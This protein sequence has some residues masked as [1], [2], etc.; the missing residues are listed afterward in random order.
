MEPVEIKTQ[1]E[2]S[3]GHLQDDFQLTED[4]MDTQKEGRKTVVPYLLEMSPEFRRLNEVRQQAWEAPGGDEYFANI[5][6]GRNNTDQ[7]N[8]TRYYKFMKVVGCELDR[9]TKAFQLQPPASHP[10]AILDFC[11]A[12]GAFLEIGLKKNPG[13]HAL[14]FTLPISCGGYRNCLEE[15]PRV[16]RVFLDVTMLAA[17]MDVD[18][19]PA[20]HPDAENFLPRQLKEDQFFDL[21]ICDGQT[22]DQHSRASY[23]E[24]RE[25]RRLSLTQLA[26]GLQH[27]RSGGTMIVSFRKLEA[28]STVNFIWTFQ[29]FSSVRLFKPKKAS[30]KRSSFYMIASGIESQHTE[31]I[32]AVARWKRAWQLATFAS[33]EEYDKMVW[34]EDPSGESLIESFGADLVD[35]GKMV[36]KI[37][38]DAL[39]EAPFMKGS[40]ESMEKE[41]GT[42]M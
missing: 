20:G 15:T 16:K 5:S 33:D 27:L 3:A 14:A 37:Q 21:I 25:G 19:I 35:L 22:L 31:A 6:R 18:Q 10:V 38:A 26:L 39:A 9:I 32:E 8:S 24:K 34:E 4:S 23:R 30:S 13:S 11:M 12:P 29:Q 42:K 28:W 2:A 36:W 1:G 17:D 40:Q 7:K 41:R